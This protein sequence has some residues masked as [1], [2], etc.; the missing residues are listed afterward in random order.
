MKALRYI[1]SNLRIS[2]LTTFS[3]LL[4]LSF[5]LVGVAFN[6][7]INQYVRSS[8]VAMLSEH[9]AMHYN[10]LDINHPVDASLLRLR[11]N[12]RNIFHARLRSFVIDGNY[13]PLNINAT[14]SA[15]DIAKLLEKMDLNPSEAHNLRLRVE[16]R[17][18][19]IT[20]VQT[21]GR[22]G[23]HII[24]YLDVTDLQRFTSIINIML[25]S[26]AAFIWIVAVIVTGFL[27][28]SLA[29]PLYI[30]RNFAKRIGNGDFDQN[31]ISFVNE[32]F[33]ALNQILNHTAKQ[34]E[35]YDND[36]KVF[37][38][39]ASHELRTP[40]MTIES[41]AEGIKYGIMSPVK[42]SKTILE[43]TGRLSDMVRDILYISRID[44]ISMPNME[45]IDINVLIQDRINKH[46]P[47]LE[48]K[49]I[50]IYFTPGKEPILVRCAVSYMG[51]ALDNLISNAMRFAKGNIVVECCDNGLQVLIR[52]TDDG[53]G[54]EPDT[55][56][57]IFERF[58]KGKNGLTG[59][60]LSVV[61]SI[62]E[63][64]KGVAIAENT[65]AGAK[66]T[67]SIPR[68]L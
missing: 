41:Y 18:Y 66:L 3:A 19:F 17:T 4:F 35:K 47:L 2:I 16:D 22:Q 67:L 42:A 56:P 33:E 9:R 30:L 11:D 34:L 55:L 59:I 64:H 23:R 24:F 20:S 32:E 63:Q 25:L 44:N 27:A 52:V 1:Q 43:A 14:H 68:N 5:A 54:F 62:M 37:F 36:Q 26:L 61:R 53:P 60:G 58:F 38:Q 13:L 6:I 40:L 29:R 31:P 28:G 48:H 21:L 49:G 50:N 39:N 45:Q 10:M 57:H 8:A 12:P 51:R 65:A 46:C 15:Y 7:V